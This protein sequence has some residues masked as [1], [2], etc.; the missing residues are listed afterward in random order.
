MGENRVDVDTLFNFRFSE[1][2]IQNRAR[3][4]ASHAKIVAPAVP[5][6][7][8]SLKVSK[9]VTHTSTERWEGLDM[10]KNLLPSVW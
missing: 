10:S 7:T 5:T 6:S 3:V 2:E 9:K 4:R 8:Q 1:R